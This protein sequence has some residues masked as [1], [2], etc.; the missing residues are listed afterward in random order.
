MGSKDRRERE[1]QETRGKIL[2]A[3]HELFV[4]DGVEAVTM[5]AIADRIEYTP[6][7]IYHHFRDKMHLVYECCMED[8]IL[9]AKEFQRL[10]KTDDP[11]ERLRQIG[12][13]YAEFGLAHPNHYRF[14]FMTPLPVPSTLKMDYQELAQQEGDPAVD[15]YAALLQAVQDAVDAGRLRPEH[16][17]AQKTAQILW[18]TMHGMVSLLIVKGENEMLK[19]H[20]TVDWMQW[21]D[22]RSLVRATCDT[23]LRGMLR[24]PDSLPPAE[25]AAAE[26]PAAAQL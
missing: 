23:V 1:R 26:E 22:P 5:R 2:E 3:A 19:Q 15:S 8:F 10:T 25:P 4:R 24:D 13:A 7:A 9:L 6:T 20:S 12:M 14:M 11:V 17:D 18:A 21:R 16:A